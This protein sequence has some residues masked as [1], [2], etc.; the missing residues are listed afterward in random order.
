MIYDLQYRCVQRSGF[1]AVVVGTDA[2]GPTLLNARTDVRP[3]DC[4]EQARS[5]K[6]DDE[7]AA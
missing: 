1:Q 2:T 3:G 5:L 7:W 6:S 4:S